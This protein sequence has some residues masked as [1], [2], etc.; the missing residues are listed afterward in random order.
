MIGQQICP[1]CQINISPKRLHSNPKVCNGCG[2]ILF[3]HEREEFASYENRSLIV[4]C[5]TAVAI[6]LGFI[7]MANWGSYS[8]E[9]IP[10]KI[11]M[12]TGTSTNSIDERMAEICTKMLKLDCVEQMYGKIALRDTKGWNRLGQLQF[13]RNK[14]A[15]ANKS[16]AIYF[17]KGG[18]DLD[19]AFYYARALAN[20]GRIDESAKH[21]ERILAAKPQIF[22]I[23]VAQTYVKILVDN[24]RLEQALKVISNQRKKGENTSRFMESE[25]RL[26]RGK[27]DASHS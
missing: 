12:M 24:G 18:K 25:Y 16:F 3:S 14:F 22:Q 23:T 26:I 8:L 7:H 19:A 5:L 1:R 11:S 17:G 15:E 2:Y 20:A 10:I 9:V 21:F 6:V 13:N 27:L 4:V